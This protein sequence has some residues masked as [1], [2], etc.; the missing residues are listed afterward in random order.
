MPVPT[1]LMHTNNTLAQTDGRTHT[2]TH[3]LLHAHLNCSCR[4]S[5]MN[6]AP[7]AQGAGLREWWCSP[8][9]GG[10]ASSPCWW[11]CPGRCVSGHCS[12]LCP[13]AH[14]T[15][16]SKCSTAP[17]THTA[18]GTSA[19]EYQTQHTKITWWSRWQPTSYLFGA[20][21]FSVSSGS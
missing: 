5:C 20:T 1:I 2:H 21:K 14:T 18:R 11:E 3:T 12:S 8:G 9:P 17:D 16:R 6:W 10:G 19:R 4:W 13:A 7:L 15:R